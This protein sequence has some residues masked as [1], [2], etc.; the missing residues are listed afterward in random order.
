MVVMRGNIENILKLAWANF[1]TQSNGSAYFY[2]IGQ[3]LF[4]INRF[5]ANSLMF[6]S[7]ATYH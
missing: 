3:I 7:I 4:I 2:L 1:F 5:F 6:S